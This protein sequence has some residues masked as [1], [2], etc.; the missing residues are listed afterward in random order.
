[1]HNLPVL[2]GGSRRCTV[3]VNPDDAEKLKIEENET[4]KVYSEFGSIDI[5]TEIT[6]D[7]IRG[8]ICIPHGWGHNSKNSKLDFA[9]RNSGSNVNVLMNHRRLDA[10]S[11]NMAF[12]GQ[13]VAI[14]RIKS[15]VRR[16][17]RMLSC[18]SA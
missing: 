14:R 3:L 18:P 7:I 4:V 11:S 5:E 10:L 1:M 8:T 12:N 2:D 13:P 16:L 6:T 9:N 15:S 17:T